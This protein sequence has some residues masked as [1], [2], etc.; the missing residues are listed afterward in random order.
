[1]PKAFAI[2]EKGRSYYSSDDAEAMRTA[3][4]LCQ[5]AKVKC[6]LYAVDDRVVWSPAE[7]A[8]ID[9]TKLQRKGP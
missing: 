6:W 3:M 5:K 1:V 7:P 9:L 2:T 8:R 4:E